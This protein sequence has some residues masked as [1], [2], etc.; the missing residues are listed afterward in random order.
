MGSWDGPANKK[1]QLKVNYNCTVVLLFIFFGLSRF[2][3]LWM[4]NSL[5][6]LVKSKQVKQAFRCVYSETSLC[7]TKLWVTTVTR[8]KRVIWKLNKNGLLNIGLTFSYFPPFLNT[9]DKYNTNVDYKNGKSIKWGCVLGIR[10]QD[11]RMVGT[12]KSTELWRPAVKSNL[13]KNGPT[14]ASFCLISIFLNK[15]YNLK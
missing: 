4:N 3:F 2:C 15:Q 1:H 12:D 6:C 7:V 14:P 9:N 10:T 11:G 13:I 8:L 5:T